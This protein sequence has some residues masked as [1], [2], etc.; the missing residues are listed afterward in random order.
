MRNILKRLSLKQA[1][2]ACCIVML[3]AITVHISVLLDLI[4]YNWINGGR[5]SSMQ[6]TTRI[7]V[8]GIFTL[9]VGAVIS[10]T[11]GDI[12]PV[13]LRK[14]G[15][16]ILRVYLWMQTIFMGV[17]IFMQLL[18]TPFEKYFLSIVVLIGFI[19]S[20]RLVIEPRKAYK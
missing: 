18:G 12:I 14:L 10:L 2:N 7:S 13:K 8:F 5:I 4:P 1:A 19:S 16:F 17:S 6:E 9:S 20:L 15:L 11:A 3:I